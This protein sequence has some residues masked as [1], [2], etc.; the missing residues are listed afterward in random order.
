MTESNKA[1]LTLIRLL[2]SRDYSEYK[3]R[4]KLRDRKY[5]PEEIDTAINLVKEKNYLRE[6][7]YAEARAK[8][9]MSKGYSQNFIKQKLGQEHVKVESEFISEIYEENRQTEDEQIE[10]LIQKKLRNKFIEDY[11]QEVKIIRFV[12]SKGHNMGQVK[13]L[14]KK[15]RKQ[16]QMN[17]VSYQDEEI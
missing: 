6:E 13:N 17:N 3:L 9:F 12:L 7:I 2:S 10:Y 5:T 8:A 11:E 14:I 4:E 16:N 15:Y 1:Y